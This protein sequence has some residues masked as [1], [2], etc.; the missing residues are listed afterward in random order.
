VQ[1]AVPIPCVIYAAKS[2]QDVRGSIPAQLAELRQAIAEDARRGVVAQ[3]IDEA[4]SGYRRDRGPGLQEAIE[5]CEDLVAD[6]GVAELWAQHSDRLARGDGRRARHTVEIALWALKNDVRVRTLQDPDT[7]R[8]LLYAVVTGQR[9]NEDSKRKG[10]ATEAGI[11][12]ALARGEPIGWTPDGYRL[13]RTLT[14]QGTV[15][16]RLE[17]DPER[18]PLIALIFRLALRGRT[19]GQIARAVNDRGWRTKPRR[20]G[21]YVHPFRPEG[22]ASFLRNPR[23]AGLAA[24][25]DDILARGCWPAYITERQHQRLIRRM[26]G[27]HTGRWAVL[28]AYLLKP[29]ARC[30]H[31]GGPLRA[32]TGEPRLDGTRRRSYV[33]ASHRFDRGNH[34]CP[35]SPIEAHMAEAMVI[36]ALPVL[37]R[38]PERVEGAISSGRY[39]LAAQTVVTSQRRTRELADVARLRD[40]ID[41]ES[42]GRDADTRAEAPRLARL[43]AGWFSKLSIAACE[44]DVAITATRRGA[45][46]VETGETVIIDRARWTRAAPHGRRNLTGTWARAEIVGAIQ[47]WVDAHGNPPSRADWLNASGTHPSRDAVT[48]MFGSWSNALLAAGYE[49]SVVFRHWS[50]PA[51]VVALR[52][53]ARAHG[54]S[55]TSSDWVRAAREHPQA[56]TVRVYFGS[57]EGAVR[58]AGLTPAPR[59]WRTRRWSQPEMIRALREWTDEHGRPPTLLDWTRSGENHP[60]GSTVC[61]RFGG[62]LIA[63]DA[64]GLTPPKR[65]SEPRWNRETVIQSLRVWTT[66]HGRR[67]VPKDFEYAT[68]GRPGIATVHRYFGS[69]HTA[70]TAAGIPTALD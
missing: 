41:R 43:L 32:I 1:E 13:V 36:A 17:F 44:T 55:P 37:L 38:E 31:C 42:T 65:K 49:P 29:I 68:D 63:L 52:A 10:A 18:Q 54:R 40:W 39:A 23:Y 20:R 64:A 30:G 21:D 62:W 27:D 11:R 50:R 56:E 25:K 19:P 35:A 47:A 12:R 5:H 57:F 69:W 4:F 16:R 46:H 28:E 15:A 34:R 2:S 14:P 61:R 7:F 60:S 33:C 70:L 53:W 48:R 67:P 45:R 59:T 24:R 66:E 22:I 58:F 9:N 51:I 26:K 8:D 6:Q 3:Y